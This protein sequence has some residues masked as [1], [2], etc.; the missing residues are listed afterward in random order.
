MSDTNDFSADRR[1]F[2]RMAGIG[3]VAGAGIFGQR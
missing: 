3:A 2:V 1:Q